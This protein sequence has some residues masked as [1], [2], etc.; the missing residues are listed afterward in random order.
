MSAEVAARAEARWPAGRMADSGMG[1]TLSA[2]LFTLAAMRAN[3][4]Q[5]MTRD[6]YA[7][8]TPRAACLA[9]ALRALF[10][11][12]RLPWVRHPNRARCESFVP[13][14][15]RHWRRGGSSHGPRALERLISP[16]PA[17]SGRAD[18]PVSQ[19]DAGVPGHA[20]NGDRRA[21]GWGGSGAGGAAGVSGLMCGGKAA[22]SP[23]M[24][25]RVS[26]TSR[27][28]KVAASCCNDTGCPP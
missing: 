5:V 8:T 7:L 15:P 6:A 22:A 16:E 11:R 14:L 13:T 25:N 18:H 20:R 19:H 9:D 10:A 3:L 27:A 4:E 24:P 21:G 12:H 28:G 26:I 23:G 17:Q 1:T 2:N